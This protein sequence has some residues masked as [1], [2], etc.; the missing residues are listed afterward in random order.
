MICRVVLMLTWLIASDAAAQAR[1]RTLDEFLDQG[2]MLT[3]AERASLTRGDPFVRTLRTGDGRDV[4]IF[5]AIQIDVPRAFFTD[6]QREFPKALRTPT[7]THVQLFSEPAAAQDVQTFV[8]SDDGLKELR[9]CKPN[10]CNFKLP[11]TDMAQARAAATPSSPDARD[12]V[13]AYAQK[14]MIEYVTDYRTRGNAAMV[15]YDDRGT[16]RS[17]D[18]FDAML[19]DS[20]YA[21]SA[22][23]S[24]GK[25]L[26]EYPRGAPPGATQLIFWS[27]D[28]IP[29]LQPVVR[30]THEVVYSPTE[31]PNTTVVAAKQ[32]YADHYFEAGLEVLAAA[33]RA[34]PDSASGAS[35]LTVVAVRRYR[36]DQL[37]SGGLLNIRGRAINGLRQ[38]LV[39]DLTRIKR[40]SEA[41]WRARRN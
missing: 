40:E 16:V 27:R 21:F 18:A 23:P 22:L 32:I 10:S 1:W 35:G 33:D 4:A 13:A 25:Y 37:P 29:H 36:F 39:A 8:V 24:L 19:G 11:A 28:E 20:S 9:D 15:I 3:A 34:S 6:Q 38:N 14:R 30:I 2:I 26:L 41:A 7:R 31:I 5:G 12:R 17:S